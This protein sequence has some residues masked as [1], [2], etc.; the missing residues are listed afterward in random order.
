MSNISSVDSRYIFSFNP[1]EN[2]MKWCSV[3]GTCLSHKLEETDEA[4]HFWFPSLGPNTTQRFPLFLF[5][6]WFWRERVKKQTKQNKTKNRFWGGGWG[7]SWSPDGEAGEAKGKLSWFHFWANPEWTC[8]FPKQLTAITKNVGHG[9]WQVLRCLTSPT[10][11]F[12]R[13]GIRVWMGEVTCPGHMAHSWQT[14]MKTRFRSAKSST[15]FL[16]AQWEPWRWCWV[17]LP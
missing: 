13:W 1:P 4:Q 11:S 8:T 7:H 5:Q 16:P 10:S 15:L 14:S 3:H 6:E 9:R 2:P 12:Y 17:T